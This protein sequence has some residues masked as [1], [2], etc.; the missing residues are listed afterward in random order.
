ME[1]PLL[2][3]VIPTW[4]RSRLVCE[5]VES[6]LAQ[7]AGAVEVIVVDDGSTDDTCGV[8]AERFGPALKLLRLPRR[9]GAQVARNAGVSLATGELLAFLDS[10][11][12]W[13]PGKLDAEL[14]VFELLPE[15][16]AVISDNL[17]FIEGERQGMSRF[18]SS[19][20]MKFSG[21]DVCWMSSCPPVWAHRSAVSTCSMTLRRDALARLGGG[22]LFADDLTS[23]EDWEFEIRL[24]HNCRVAVL[25][26]VWS[27]VRQFD[28]GTRPERATPGKTRTIAQQ[29][30]FLRGR[31]E[32]LERS[33]RLDWAACDIPRELERA[34]CD[35]AAM[36]A[37]GEGLEG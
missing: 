25:P 8:L 31:V 4:N 14:R 28:D 6:A 15:A 3:V 26:E 32:V 10:D 7:R 9:A 21:G 35:T 37:R 2:S 33:L 20:L 18:E 36:L 1:R 23:H 27:H 16:E 5:A 29:F 17:Y 30:R 13:L 22:H 24:F 12:I 11:D 34:R 19:G